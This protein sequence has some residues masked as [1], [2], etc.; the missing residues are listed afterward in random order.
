[1]NDELGYNDQLFSYDVMMDVFND[2]IAVRHEVA[3]DFMDSIKPHPVISY[4]H[5]FNVQKRRLVHQ[6]DGTYESVPDAALLVF[7]GGDGKVIHYDATD[8]TNRN[9]EVGE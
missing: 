9:I 7:M 1:M 5:T 4:D 6:P 3:Q 8:K 2:Y